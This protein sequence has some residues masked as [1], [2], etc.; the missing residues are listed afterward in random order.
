MQKIIK[1][2]DSVDM[3]VSQCLNL[4]WEVLAWTQVHIVWLSLILQCKVHSQYGGVFAHIL[5]ALLD[6]L[7]L[8]TSLMTSFNWL[9]I[10]IGAVCSGVWLFIDLR[11]TERSRNTCVA[12]FQKP[13]VEKIEIYVFFTS[14][15]NL[16]L[17]IIISDHNC[18]IFQLCAR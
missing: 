18:T 2:G 17:Q 8:N 4:M 10:F 7:M 3:F 5:V 12:A 15:P 9:L 13:F 14:A 6:I 16:F 1:F 11:I